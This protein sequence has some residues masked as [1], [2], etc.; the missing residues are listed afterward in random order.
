MKGH[1]DGGSWPK[2]RWPHGSGTRWGQWTVQ[3]AQ[4]KDLTVSLGAEGHG[5]VWL[6]LW[7]NC[8]HARYYSSS[9]G[10]QNKTLK[11]KASILWALWGAHKLILYYNCQR[12]NPQSDS[13]E[14]H[15]GILL[16]SSRTEFWCKLFQ[17]MEKWERDSFYEDH[18]IKNVKACVGL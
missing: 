3:H 6:A 4:R 15:R 14:F 10:H 13:K 18:I 7:E 9:F 12:V 2:T 11:T 5:P 16:I 8:L 1:G 17:S